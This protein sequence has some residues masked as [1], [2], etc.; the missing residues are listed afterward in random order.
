MQPPPAI[1]AAIA[2]MARRQCVV[3]AIEAAAFEQQRAFVQ[4]ESPLVALLCPRRAGKSRAGALRLFRTAVKFPGSQSRYFGLTRQTSKDIMWDVLKQV[5]EELKI[6]AAFNETELRTTLPNGSSF[7]LVGMDANEK[8]RRKVLG[9]DLKDAILDEAASFH[10]DLRALIKDFIGPATIRQRGTIALTGTPDPDEA[11]GFF[12]EVTTGKEPGW[13][14]HSWDTLDNPYMREEW[15]AKLALIT[16]TDP[17][18]LET[19][20]FRCMYRAEW[21][22]SPSGWVYQF[23][24]TRNV[25]DATDLPEIHHAVL[26]I[27]LGWKDDFALTLMGWNR[28]DKRIF[29]L[30]TEKAPK[31]YLDHIAQRADVVASFVKCHVSRVIDGANQQ[32]VQELRKRYK[33][34]A[35]NTDKADK[36]GLIRIM[37]TELMCGRVLA[38]RGWVDETGHPRGSTP[39]VVEWSGADEAGMAVKDATP[40]VWDRRAMQHR[41]PRLVEDSRCPNHAADAALYAFRYAWNYLGRSE[42]QH[43]VPG[44]EEA[45][46]LERERYKAKLMRRVREENAA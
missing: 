31:K 30:H 44:T 1:A 14:P 15:A 39:L 35:E 3:E 41:P 5:N 45:M 13:T 34:N 6:G 36:A 24:R 46:R 40:L 22:D 16:E 25:I 42:T 12:Y 19:P 43:V 29:I 17:A 10:V 33:L 28:H 7:R 32:V 9:G 23:N 11:R 2:E 18:Y 4:D 20:E 8:E 21:P 26:G 37:N 38:V 27:D